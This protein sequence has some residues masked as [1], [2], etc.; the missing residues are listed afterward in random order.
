MEDRAERLRTTGFNAEM[1]AGDASALS[2][3]LHRESRLGKLASESNQ[4]G[5]GRVEE[6]ARRRDSSLLE[7]VTRSRAILR[8]WSVGVSQAV[9]PRRDTMCGRPSAKERWPLRRPSQ[10]ARSNYSAAMTGGALRCF[11]SSG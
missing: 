9:V 8:R 4:D 2:A 3:T 11:D 7:E 5:L 6:R 1:A 10:R